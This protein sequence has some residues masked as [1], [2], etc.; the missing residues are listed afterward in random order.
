[1]ETVFDLVLRHAQI[2]PLVTTLAVIGAVSG[3]LGILIAVVA[4]VRK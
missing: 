2:M 3:P 1:M 4:L